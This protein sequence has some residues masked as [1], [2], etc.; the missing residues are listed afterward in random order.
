MKKIIASV[1]IPFY[2]DANLLYRAIESITS[3]NGSDSVEIIVVN[4]CSKEIFDKS[5]LRE[6]DIYIEMGI[7]SGAAV[8]RNIGIKA[9]HGDLIYLM[10]SDDYFVEKDFILDHEQSEPGVLYYSGIDSQAYSSSYPD[11]IK[12]EDYFDYIFYKYPHIC[13]TSSLYFKRSNDF[14]FDESLPKHQ[15]WDFVYFS[16][17]KKGFSVKKGNGTIY[18]D[19]SDRKSLSR[20]SGG[21]KSLAWINKLKEMSVLNDNIVFHLL[22]QYPRYYTSSIFVK[23]A[24]KYLL[25]GRTSIK[26]VSYKLVHRIMS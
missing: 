16:V 24:F 10:D 6:H 20:G 15:D 22:A 12:L 21:E 18:F 3:S 19:R 9:S 17:L 5:S 25:S 1:V 8:S 2:K 23:N 7:N 4:D 14:F 13:Q 11:E 26:F